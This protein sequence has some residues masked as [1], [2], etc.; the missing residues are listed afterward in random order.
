M[1]HRY[2]NEGRNWSR[3]ELFIGGG[4]LISILEAVT[5]HQLEIVVMTAAVNIEHFIDI[6]FA[7]EASSHCH[8][9]AEGLEGKLEGQLGRIVYYYARLIYIYVYMCQVH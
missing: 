5:T 8:F 6:P 9:P 3:L 2:I 7:G 1:T 4:D